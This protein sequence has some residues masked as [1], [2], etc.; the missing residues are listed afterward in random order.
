MLDGHHAL[1]KVGQRLD[2]RG[3]VALLQPGLTRASL[4]AYRLGPIRDALCAANLNQVLSALALQALEV[5][6]I[7]PPWLHQDTTTMALSGAYADEPQSARAPRLAYGHSTDGRNDLT[8]VLLRL[9]VRGD[10]GLPLRVGVRDGNRSERVDTPVAI[11][12]GLALGLEGGRG[13]VADSTAE[14][15]R[16]LG[17]CRER[18][19]GLVTF[20]PRTWAIRQDREAWGRQQPAWPLLVEKPGRTQGEAPRR[21]HGQSVMRRGEVEDSDGLVTAEVLRFVVVHSSQLAQQQAQTY[22]SAQGKAAE[23]LAAHATRVQ[24]QWFA[25]W[26]DA[27]A[28]LAAYEGQEQGRRGRRPR[29]WRSHAVRSRGVAAT[30]PT[31]RA[32][33]GRPAKTDPPPIK[34]GYRLA[35][36]GEALAHPEEDHGWTVL[37]TPGSAAGCTDAEILQASQ[38]QNTTVDPGCRW[39]KNPAA[40]SPVWLEHPE[41]LAA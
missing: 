5:S 41:R 16:T 25:C 27:H 31:R 17:V 39:S 21:W 13:L 40:I 8:Q 15:R 14:G 20:V 29:P 11:E 7:P 4:H 23:T 24:A 28:A 34:A 33:R 36:E 32:R 19:L 10:G 38:A 3:L 12:A 18:Q 9:G 35:V 30:R 37:A 2:E 26:P 1:S 22:T 6:A